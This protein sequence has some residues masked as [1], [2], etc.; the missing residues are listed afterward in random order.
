MARA[1]DVLV[2]GLG[3]AGSSAAAAAARAG[4]S[5][6]CLE[7]KKVVGIPVQCAEFIPLP[8]S[9]YAAPDARAQAVEAMATVLPSGARTQRAFNGLMI[10]RDRFDQALAHAAREAGALLWTDSLLRAVDVGAR[11]V[12]V[13]T[14]SGLR[15]VGYRLLI[16]ADGPQSQVAACLGLPRLPLVTTRQYTV[17]LCRAQR[18]TDIWLSPQTPGGYAWLFPKGTVANLGLGVDPA[19]E[20]DMKAPLDALHAA[21]VA[22]RRVGADILLRTGGLIPVGGLRARLVEGDVLFVGDA[23]GFTHP[24][25]GAGIAPAVASGE[26]AGE[27]AARR[28]AGDANAL[29]AYEAEMREQFEPS[30]ARGLRARQR[31]AGAWNTAGAARDATHRAGWIAF[32]E[33]YAAGPQTAEPGRRPT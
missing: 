1:V 26:R 3:P 30:L 31:M 32:D 33:Y 5:V 6:L 22:E 20:A 4:A 10:K 15:E 23:A 21:L 27:A 17:P 9:R 25:T 24:V 13:S 8:L 11:R 12:R 28:L 19:L 2:I 16:A 29:I 14:A 18:D 7:R